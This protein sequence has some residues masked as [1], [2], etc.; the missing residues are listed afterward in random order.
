VT[1]TTEVNPEV[2]QQKIGVVFAALSGL[3]TSSMIHLGYELSLYRTMA[4]KG[5]MTAA[6]L[7]ADAGLVQRFGRSRLPSSRPP[8]SWTVAAT[9]S[10]S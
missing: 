4:G 7:A 9:D 8:D 3:V 10:S 1:T 5:P 2:V 6:Q